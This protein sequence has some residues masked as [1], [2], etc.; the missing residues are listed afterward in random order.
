MVAGV[1]FEP[2]DLRIM[3]PT[4]YRTAL[5]RDIERAVLIDLLRSIVRKWNE[6]KWCQEV[7][8]NHWPSAYEADAL[9]TELSGHIDRCFYTGCCGQCPVLR[10]RF[11]ITPSAAVY[12]SSNG[13]R[14][15]VV[16]VKGGCLRPLD[17]GAILNL[18]YFALILIRV[19][20]RRIATYLISNTVC[21][22]RAD[23]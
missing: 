23:R 20:F 13:I 7:G 5:P 3:S 16:H 4:S 11:R 21:I 6:S 1:G 14:T 18:F 10:E 8:S 12:G 22:M 19:V 9:P 15:R 17:Y 2:H